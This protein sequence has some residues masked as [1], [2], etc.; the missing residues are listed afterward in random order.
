MYGR[1]QPGTSTLE[2]KKLRKKAYDADR[3]A[4]ISGDVKEKE[5]RAAYQKL[6]E[7]RKRERVNVSRNE[8]P[9]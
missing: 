4:K 8:Q 3:W 5:R 7:A 6:Y 9:D 2:E 1:R